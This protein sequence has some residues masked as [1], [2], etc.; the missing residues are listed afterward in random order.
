MMILTITFLLIVHPANSFDVYIV[1][2]YT[3]IELFDDNDL[4]LTLVNC[5]FF[6]PIHFI[7]TLYKK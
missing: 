3:Y 1:Q 6:L 4:D 5:T 7:I 2:I